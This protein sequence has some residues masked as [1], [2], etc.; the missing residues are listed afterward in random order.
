MARSADP[1]ILKLRKLLDGDHEVLDDEG[2][3][4]GVIKHKHLMDHVR[5]FQERF[6]QLFSPDFGNHTSSVDREVMRRTQEVMSETGLPVEGAMARVL[7]SDESLANK[8]HRAHSEVDDVDGPPRGG[9]SVV[10]DETEGP[11]SVSKW[12]CILASRRRMTFIEE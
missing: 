7:A 4:L 10:A 2:N 9:L 8:Y 11:T 1:K 6:E 5:A 12:A 3:S